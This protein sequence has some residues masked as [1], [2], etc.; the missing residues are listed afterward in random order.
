[1]EIETYYKDLV[2]FSLF[3]PYASLSVWHVL[4]S[5]KERS[6][7][8]PLPPPISPSNEMVHYWGDFFEGLAETWSL[9][10]DLSLLFKT[11]CCSIWSPE[12]G[13]KPP[14]P[15]QVLLTKIL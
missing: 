4:Y 7:L 11:G 9:K 8:R 13:K 5:P 15:V 3:S 14:N 12:K 6:V 10:K 2:A 1:M